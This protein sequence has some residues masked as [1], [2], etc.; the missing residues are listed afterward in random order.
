MRRPRSSRAPRLFAAAAVAASLTIPVTAGTA[1]AAGAGWC[2]GNQGAD[3]YANP[4]SLHPHD[5]IG[6]VSAHQPVALL[7]IRTD[8]PSGGRYRIDWRGTTGWTPQH[9]VGC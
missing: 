6:S 1:E 3:L 5:Y 8:G 9:V 2:T 7:E 4:D